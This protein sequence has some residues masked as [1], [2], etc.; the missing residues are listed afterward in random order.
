ME[1]EK[2]IPAS[3]GVSYPLIIKQKGD[4]EILAW[5]DPERLNK[6]MEKRLAV[7]Y[8]EP[9]YRSFCE[10]TEELEKGI[11]GLRGAVNPIDRTERNEKSTSSK[12]EDFSDL[13][14]KA[15]SEKMTA[16][17]LDQLVDEETGEIKDREKAAELIAEAG[18]QMHQEIRSQLFGTTGE[19]E[20]SRGG[21]VKGM[22]LGWTK[23]ELKQEARALNLTRIGSLS[24]ERLAEL[25]KN[26]ILKPK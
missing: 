3:Q 22:L 16:N 26:E 5:S 21:S 10:I 2:C 1:I 20:E 9:D 7:H 14:L 11:R 23:E 6:D 15:Y 17:I 12:L 8:G 4:P 19:D 13:F 18:M 24:K 25:I